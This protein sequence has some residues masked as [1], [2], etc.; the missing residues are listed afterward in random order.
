[1]R[2][3]PRLALDVAERRQHAGRQ[4][5]QLRKVTA[6]HRQAADLGGAERVRQRGRIGLKEWSRPSNGDGIDDGAECEREIETRTNAGVDLDRLAQRPL[7]PGCF[8]G[9][10]VAADDQRRQHVMTLRIGAGARL[11][12][13][14]RSGGHGRTRQDAAGRVADASGDGALVLLGR[15]GRA[16]QQE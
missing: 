1:M 2:V 7:E 5:R 11:G 12:A 10:L 16:R 14:R 9:D 3:E 4:H 13:S 15:G 6:V 8:D